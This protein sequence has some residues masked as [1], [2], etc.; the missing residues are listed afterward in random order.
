MHSCACMLISTTILLTMSSW[1]L[2]NF[3]MKAYSLRIHCNQ[4]LYLLFRQNTLKRWLYWRKTQ[5][6]TSTA[7][8][9]SI[10]LR[11]LR[12]KHAINEVSQ[13]MIKTVAGKLVI[14][15]RLIDL[16]SQIRTPKN[17]LIKALEK[18]AHQY[19]FRLTKKVS[20]NISK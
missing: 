11:H 14:V 2:M 4:K 15:T 19:H 10:F 20:K 8:S 6:F 5:I 17:K 18:T 7:R 9:N 3:L 12:V 13:C 1:H 16:R